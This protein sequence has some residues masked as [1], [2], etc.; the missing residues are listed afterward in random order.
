MTKISGLAARSRN[1][2]EDM[3]NHLKLPTWFNMLIM[4]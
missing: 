2:N 4:F 1:P 3:E